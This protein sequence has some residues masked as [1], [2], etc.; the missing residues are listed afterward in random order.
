MK[1]SITGILEKI[2]PIEQ[3]PNNSKFKQELVI[4]EEGHG[5]FKDKPFLIQRWADSRAKLIDTNL[6]DFKGQEVTCEVYLNGYSYYHSKNGTSYGIN[7][8]LANIQPSR[9]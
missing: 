2:M 4:I 9:V 6:E 8:T 7:L 3:M 1:A 5:K